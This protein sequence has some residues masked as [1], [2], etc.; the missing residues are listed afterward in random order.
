MNEFEIIRR[1]FS[2]T[3]RDDAVRLGIGDD[4]AVIAPS[5]GQELVIAVDTMNKGR[6]FFADVP[7]VTLGHKILAVNLSDMAAMGATPRWALLAGSLE[8]SDADWLAAFCA[9]FYTLAEKYRIALVGGDTTRG[10]TSFTLTI[11]GETPAG[12]AITRGGARVDDDIWV[13]GQ[14]GDAA[15]ALAAIKKQVSLSPE[16][17]AL[18][19]QR[20][21]IP[22]PRVALGLGLRD[23]ATA[24]LDISDGLSGD[25][26]H[27]LESSQVGARIEL[28]AIPRSPILNAAFKEN[29]TL[30]LH[31]LLAGG[32]DYELCFTA[33][34]S[35]RAHIDAISQSLELPLTRIGQITADKSFHIIDENGRPLHRLPDAFDH[36]AHTTHA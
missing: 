27:I 13:S 34:V 21:E 20:L 4:A 15:L 12:K 5:P 36:F 2:H 26:R 25:L 17:I 10:A 33:P 22:E 19:R 8:D 24:A 23:I 35:A 11:I 6:H 3:Y 14:L 9:G 7:P 31:C 29:K 1:F 28:D 16:N 18:L 30:A 32:D